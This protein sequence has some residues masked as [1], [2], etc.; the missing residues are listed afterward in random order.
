MIK[1]TTLEQF[2]QSVYTCL[3]VFGSDWR[4]LD[5]ISGTLKLKKKSLCK[6]KIGKNNFSLLLTTFFYLYS[7]GI[8]HCGTTFLLRRKMAKQ[9]NKIVFAKKKID[10][11]G[12]GG[13]RMV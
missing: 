8:I 10:K 11:V 3:V 13:V 12:G 4:L 2:C 6:N 1:L 5:Q 7:G 9:I